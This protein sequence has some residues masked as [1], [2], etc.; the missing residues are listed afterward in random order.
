MPNIAPEGS[1]AT[2]VHV[3]VAAI[4]NARGEVLVSRRPDHVHQGGLWEF[5][6]GKV[7]PGEAVVDALVREI[8]EELGIRPTASRPLIRIPHRYPD[9]SVLLDVWKVDGIS[10]EPHGREGQAVRWQAIDLLAPDDFPAANVP[11]IKALQL[12]TA[13][14]ITPEPDGCTETFLNRLNASLAQGARLVQLRAKTLGDRAY[15]TLAREVIRVC[16]AHGAAVLLNSAPEL[17]TSLGADGVHLDS[18][19]LAETPQRPLASGLWVAASCH[20]PG[21]L[22]RAEAVQA[23][24]AVLSPVSATAS[25]PAVSPIGWHR[26]SQW[27]DG[28]KIPVYA[29]GGMSYAD[30]DAAIRH[31]AQGIAGISAL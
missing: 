4:V 6:G 13:Y 1:N 2:A 16:H 17:V 28:C 19:R 25:H 8:Y 31:G 5:P 29:L 12:P 14:L 26:F 11:I 9:R 15:A 24:F 23:D 27:V 18:R 30:I 22:S 7:E 20:S 21:E 3:A 10:G